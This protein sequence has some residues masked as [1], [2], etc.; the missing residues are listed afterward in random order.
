MINP[1]VWAA[2]K[3][4]VRK[5]VKECDALRQVRVEDNV[6]AQ[7][8]FRKKMEIAT[9]LIERL[10]VDKDAHD[11]TKFEL[12][13][14]DYRCTPYV[15]PEALRRLVGKK[16]ET[17]LTVRNVIA[18]DSVFGGAVFASGGGNASIF[19][20]MGFPGFPYLTELTMIT[21]YRD[22]SERVAAE[23]CRKWIEFRTSGDDKH[24]KEIEIIEAELKRLDARR[25]F[26]MAA[27]L[28][29]FFGRCQIFMDL[30]DTEGPEL[31]T[32][33]MLNKYKIPK[34]SLRALKLI[35]PITTYPAMY[36][37]SW[38]L[39]SDYYVPRSWWVYGEQVHSDRLLTFVS[40]PLPDLLK[41]VF[42]FSG[43]SLS[44][45]AEPYV[46]YWLSTRDSVGKLLRNFSTSVLK[47][48]MEGVL[49][50][51]NYDNFMKRAALFNLLRDNQGL[52]LLDM[53]GSD[54]VESRLVDRQGGQWRVRQGPF[55][56]RSLPPVSRPNWTLLVQGLDQGLMLLDMETED[57]AKHETSLAGL[58]KLQA[59]AQEHMAAVAKTPLVILLGITPTGL[60]GSDEQG[61]RI[62]YD[63]VADMQENIF[64]HNLD[65]LIK[66]IM[67]SKFG[68]VFDDI[69]FE[70][71]S[72][73]SMTEK[74]RALIHRSDAEEAQALIQMGVVSPQETRAK[75][76]ADPDSG[77]TNLDVAKPE[78]K[79]LKPQPA[80]AKSGGPMGNT[81]KAENTQEAGA[82]FGGNQ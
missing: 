78:G 22:M 28:D 80:G 79:L 30:G 81:E 7:A 47:T 77:W 73:M 48:N 54:D 55:K 11:G 17:D 12:P 3:W 42:N 50:G 5:A 1:F 71:V 39:K 35:E 65:R 9:P 58:D 56:R 45:L 14:P 44:Q 43:M 51:D 32:P 46:N 68:E 6:R 60:N 75:I 66:V 70:F 31:G 38:P 82:E 74:E 26:R 63:Y 2:H 36:N 59:Q 29:G 53:A 69:T 49:Q 10:Q 57:F 34:D 62:F 8:T 25:L 33:L 4:N 40:R 61:L 41:P 20:G 72:L 19:S 15:P 23:M 37:S 67:L 27:T 13:V 16:G 18:S 64:R 52:M 21:E 76:A 24:T